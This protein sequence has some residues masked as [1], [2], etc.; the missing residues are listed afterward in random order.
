MNSLLVNWLPWS[1]FMI[2]GVPYF[3]IASSNAS[4]GASVVRLF[5]SRHARTR[6]VAQSRT[7]VKYT[8]RAPWGYT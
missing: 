6:R 4:T 3:V 5:D 1:V 8:S 7:T 2:S